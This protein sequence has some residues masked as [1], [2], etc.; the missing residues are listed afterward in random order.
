MKNT[1]STQGSLL[2]SHR[3]LTAAIALSLAALAPLS[4]RAAANSNEGG[5]YSYSNVSP[6][7]NRTTGQ[8]GDQI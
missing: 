5:E 8:T 1:P 2:S 4:A 7:D 3:L 6:A